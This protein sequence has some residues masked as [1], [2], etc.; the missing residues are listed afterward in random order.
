MKVVFLQDVHG[1]GKKDEIKNVSDGYARN[2]LLKKNLAKQIDDI[3]IKALKEKEE[4]EKRKMAFELKESQKMAEKLDGED[5][6]IS[7]KV[8]DKGVLY[9]AIKP[10]EIAEAIQKE[11]KLSV[12]PEQIII[13]NPIKELGEHIVTIEFKHGLEAE[14]TVF[15]T[16]N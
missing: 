6:S 3:G 14:L 10:E 5:V 15:V 12:S 1:S 7:G 11:Y 2:F 13:E 16:E 8:N 4:K 9:A